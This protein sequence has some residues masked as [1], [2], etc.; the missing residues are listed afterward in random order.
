M[1][2]LKRKK[3]CCP[4]FKYNE[5]VGEADDSNSQHGL[6]HMLQAV[7][8]N[9]LALIKVC[10]FQQLMQVHKRKYKFYCYTVYL[11]KLV[12]ILYLNP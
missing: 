7:N 11:I 2:I 5:V 6:Y 9:G 10:T 1:E 3:L 12:L 8:E 4:T